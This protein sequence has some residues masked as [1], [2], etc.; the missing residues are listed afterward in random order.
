MRDEGDE[1]LRVKD[2]SHRKG[3]AHELLRGRVGGEGGTEFRHPAITAK[4]V[5]ARTTLDMLDV[6]KC[7]ASSREPGDWVNGSSMIRHQVPPCS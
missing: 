6:G 5:Y 3:Q 4:R 7:K 1:R 2:G